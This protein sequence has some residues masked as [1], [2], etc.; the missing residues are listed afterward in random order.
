MSAVPTVF[1]LA[2]ST[3][4]WLIGLGFGIILGG[5]LPQRLAAWKQGVGVVVLGSFLVGMILAL[6]VTHGRQ[7]F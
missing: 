3:A 4:T 1:V 7:N 2:I 5:K 6:F